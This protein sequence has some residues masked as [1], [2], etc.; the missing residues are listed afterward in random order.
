M[1]ILFVHP[2]FPGPFAALAATL[3]D[4]AAHP[5]LALVA[6]QAEPPAPWQGVTL[7]ACPP[8]RASV[9]GLHPWLQEAERQT[10]RGEAACHAALQLQEQGFTPDVIVAHPGSGDS[11]FLLPSCTN[12]AEASMNSVLFSRL[13]FLST[14]M[15]VAMV[16][17]KKRFC[18]NWITVST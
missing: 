1:K 5:V 7:V 18:G 14:M 8:P 6:A 13:F 4:D 12:S 11:L 9:E 3:A 16:T 10:L 2:Y 15:Q 17:P